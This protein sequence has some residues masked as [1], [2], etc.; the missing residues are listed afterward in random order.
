MA[1]LIYELTDQAHSPILKPTGETFSLAGHNLI[2]RAW[3]KSGQ[4][5]DQGW[6]ISADELIR[7]HSDGQESYGTRR[8]I[9]DFDPKAKRRIGLIELL[10]IYA[11][12]HGYGSGEA[13]W[14]PL[15]L[16]MRY[17]FYKEYE[18][19]ITEEHKSRIIGTIPL[20]EDGNDFVEFLY[21]NGPD[22]GWNWG[23]NGMTNAAFLQ[24]DARAYFRK[25][26]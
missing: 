23:K 8:L 21:L 19:E 15:M 4:P 16:R 9:I 11:Y 6:H 7:L 20:S 12:T 14:T 1:F 18:S 25:F 10:D 17:A 2:Y 24:G 3:Q 22:K 13:S 26:F 5:T